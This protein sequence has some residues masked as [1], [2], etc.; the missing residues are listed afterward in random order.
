MTAFANAVEHARKLLEKSSGE[1]GGE[2]DVT[3]P[4]G[5]YGDL[6][7][8]IAF[9][10]AKKQG[11]N[12]NEL[13]AK[14][15][16][17]LS[18]QLPDAFFDKCEPA[19]GYVNFF[20]SDALRAMALSQALQ[21]DYATG[22]EGQG[23]TF[24]LEYSQP[25]VGKP[26]HVGHIRST[27]L[28]DSI[29]NFLTARG[30]SVK[31]VNYIGDAGAQV[32]KLVLASREFKDLPPMKDERVMLKYY[33]RVHQEIEE[34]P[35]LAQQAQEILAAIEAGDDATL[36]EVLFIRSKSYEAFQRNYDML[37][38]RFDD[39]L[40]ESEFIA[41]SKEIAHEALEKK[42]AFK[43]DKTAAL[44][45]NLEPRG[46]PNTILLRSNGTT[47]YFTRDMALADWKWGKYEFDEGLVTT[48]TE[49]NT[50]FK[51]VIAFLGML[52]RDYAPR[53]KHMG[54]GLVTLQ[55]E[56]MS[57]RE[58]RVV[59]MEDVLNAA[60]DEVKKELSQREHDYPASEEDEIARTVGIGSVKFAF[61]K[62][63][64][65][66]N[67]SFNPTEAVR[68]DGDTGAYLQYTC[69]RARNILRKAG[70]DATKLK[71]PARADFNEYERKVVYAL[72]YFPEAVSHSARNY[73]PH[74]TCDY[75]LKLAAAF[76][77]F[78]E[79]CPVAT[80]QEPDK[81]KRLAIA[82]ATASVIESGLA[83]LGIQVPA[84]M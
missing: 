51:Q 63:G 58:G 23:R 3:R 43:D 34:K 71:A 29:G 83:L 81:S 39:V 24:V 38:V 9:V 76:S 67:I 37:G 74:V 84:R 72:A 45:A 68:F 17:Q 46:L 40:G 56:K 31:R 62:V 53:Y 49:Q 52:G 11:G 77:E 57:T 30:W 80:A 50:Y 47:L 82:A 42:I 1:Q 26:F 7:S 41:R 79:K 48:S 64:N 75:L 35:E 6:A 13:A 4:R 69:V 28:G 20:F 73:E 27:I 59:L 18:T 55:G 21:G 36:K 78:Y 19:G 33:V 22:R 12:P 8:P 2:I 16:A 15:A 70:I 25:N 60:I 54:F 32:S 5:E 61:L 14:L 44:V 10:L 66:K 65:S